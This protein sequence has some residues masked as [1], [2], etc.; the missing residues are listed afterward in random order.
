[1]SSAQQLLRSIPEAQR[2][3]GVWPAYYCGVMSGDDE[4]YAVSIETIGEEED[5]S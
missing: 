4:L 2:E 5:L 3:Y 1:M